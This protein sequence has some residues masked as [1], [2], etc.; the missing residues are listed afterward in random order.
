M[1]YVP[2]HEL[3]D[4]ENLI[5][6][7]AANEHTVLT[8][9]HWPGS[10]TPAA[11][12]ADL[13][14]EIAF[15]YLDQAVYHVDVD[16]VS[17]NHFDEDGLVSLWTI[18]H[19]HEARL[20]RELLIDVAAAGDFG[21]Y[22][23]RRAP[24]VAF[25]LSTYADPELSPLGPTTFNL[26]SADQ[27]GTLFEELLP[28]LPELCDH[29]ERYRRLW[30][31]EDAILTES[32]EAVCTGRVV[33]EEV[34][35]LDLAVVSVPEESSTKRVHRFAQR[36]LQ[37]VHPIAIYNATSHFRILQV[38][39]QRYEF[40]YRYESWVRYTSRRPPPRVD[41][42]PLADRLS[43]LERNGRWEADIVAHLTPRLALVDGVESS[44]PCHRLR[45]E[46]ERFLAD[47][48]PAWNPYE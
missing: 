8:L 13:S 29:P 10:R 37:A 18:L 7:G 47:A 2:Y 20:R 33:I 23:D 38:Q 31:A 6:D 5:V 40:H 34:P 44:I 24:R 26:D 32:E 41:L 9:S 43:S 27:V 45:A 22:H 46:L 42:V 39:G 16:V 25:A 36:R 11:L 1:R 14:A 21:T 3:G 15:H 12:E 48:P 4:V 17:N 35:G 19:P 28:R 30:E